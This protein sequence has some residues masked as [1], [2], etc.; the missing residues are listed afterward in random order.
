MERIVDL[1]WFRLILIAIG[2]PITLVALVGAVY[3]V[4]LTMG[5]VQHGLTFGFALGLMA[6]FGLLGVVGAWLRL[7][8]GYRE[9][10]QRLRQFTRVLLLCGVAS[11]GGMGLTAAFVFAGGMGM[12]TAYTAAAVAVLI[13]ALLAATGL[14]LIRATPLA[15]RATN[16]AP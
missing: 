8:I 2:V 12:G 15:A 16:P 5:S 13:S 6:L 7:S 10:S 9:M 1:W 11:I 14:L 4:F 3:G